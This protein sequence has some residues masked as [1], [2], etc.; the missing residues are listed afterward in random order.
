MNTL[1]FS[2]E[3]Y[4]FK[5]R[6]GATELKVDMNVA[7]EFEEYMNSVWSKALARLKEICE[8]R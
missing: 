6:D 1:H 8:R 4:T 5:E 7:P 2:I 3:N